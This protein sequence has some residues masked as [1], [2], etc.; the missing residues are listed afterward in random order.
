MHSKANADGHKENGVS[1]P[2]GPAQ[3]DLMISTYKEAGICPSEVFYVEAHG[4]GTSA[5]DP[6]EL[7]AIS[8]VFCGSRTEKHPPLL[9]GSTKSNM[10][11]AEPAASLCSVVK[12]ALSIQHGVIPPN[13]HFMNP[14]PKV[15]ALHDGRLKVLVNQ[16]NK[17]Y[18]EII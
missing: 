8:K 1:F 15:P 2:S 17:Q 11:H 13:L 5:G 9:I 14:N 6:E 7:Q 4:T 18:Q 16:I 3:E 10:G 12:I